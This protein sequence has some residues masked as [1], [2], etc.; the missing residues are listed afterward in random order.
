MEASVNLCDY[1]WIPVAGQKERKSLLQ[2]FSDLSL[3]RLSGNPVDKIVILRL[4]LCIAHASNKIPDEEAWLA[5]T[6]EILGKNAVT[7]LKEHY[8]EFFLYGEKPFLQFPQL[9]KI[10]GKADSLGSLIV[11][12]AEGNK[13][14]L[15]G[16]NQFQELSQAEIIVLLLRSACYACGGKKYDKN[17]TISKGIVKGA[18]GRNG[19]LLGFKGYLHSY[20]LGENI[21]NT[22]KLNLLT[23]EEINSTYAFPQGIGKPFWEAMPEGEQG[24]TTE[25]YQQS[26]L[27]HLIPIDKFYLLMNTGIVKTDGIN[28]PGHKDGLIDPALTIF[29]DAKNPRAIWS[30]T[31]KRPWRELTSLFAFLESSTNKAPYFLSMGLRKMR[32]AN[33]THL[34]IWTGGMEVNSK[35]GE[36][37]LSEKNDYVE[38]EFC[39]PTTCLNSDGLDHLKDMIE[40]AELK[41]KQL[42]ICITAYYKEM[43]D[44][45]PQK[46]ADD[47]RTR[48]WELMESRAQTILELAFSDTTPEQR[49]EEQREWF[50]FICDVYDE[51]CPHGTARQLAAWVKANPRFITK[52]KK[53]QGENK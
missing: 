30:S 10:G 2:V 22:V 24:E 51:K 42:S 37:Y 32:F 12:V 20:M 45:S 28:Y 5:L 9:G 33:L 25:K 38:S 53:K 46:V 50:K 16:W 41:S 13:V 34:T 11:N 8:D 18:T 15:S 39:L 3:R 7:Y 4:L 48:Y 17:L 19:T 35:L 1:P 26:Y 43:N 27:G 44:D 6:P 31:T 52:D 40:N 23:E 36:Q 47:G 14:V 49:Q 21:V 29:P